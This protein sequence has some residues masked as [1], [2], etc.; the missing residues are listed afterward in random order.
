MAAPT[1]LERVTFNQSR[2]KTF[3][4]CPKQYEYKYV[5]LIE[6]KSKIRPLYLGSWVHRALETFY[7]KGDWRIG[8]QEYVESWNKLFDEEKLALRT[9]GKTVGPPLPE[10]VERI[11]KSYQW[12][13][14]NDGWQVVMV[15]EVLETETPLRIGERV[16]IFKGRLDLLIR[17]DEGLLWL[18][19]HK[20]TSSIPQ[21][22]A[23]HAMDPQLMLYPWAA[24]RSRDLK[25]AGVIYNYVM[26][27]APTIPKLN[28]DGSLSRRKVRTDYPTLLRFLKQSGYDP[29]DFMDVLRPLSRKSEFLRRYKLPRE[30]FVT[31]EIVL[32]ALSTVK[33][34]DETR[35]FTRTITRDCVRCPYM[36][37]CQ[38]ELN[39]FDTEVLRRTNYQPAEEDYVVSDLGAIFEDADESD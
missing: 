3:A 13:Y 37:I 30:E 25:I 2:I 35:R 11:M 29:H 9:R 8:H 34:I 10:L 26:S 33:R 7:T 14:R 1:S 17:D 24:E 23:F 4:R 12:Y 32:D 22:T 18:V 39:G 5:Q 28:R 15:E 6:P 36:T 21:P 27:K 19:D 38:A 16:W 20:T 31:K